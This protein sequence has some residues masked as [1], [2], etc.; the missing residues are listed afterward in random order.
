[1]ANTLFLA[2]QG[3]LQAWGERGRWA[4]RDSALLPTKSGIVGLLGCALGWAD[5][6]RLLALSQAIEIGV[7]ADGPGVLLTDYHTVVGGVLSAS[8]K[9]KR[10][11]TTKELE[12]VVS[13]RDYIA[14]AAFLAAI[15][16]PEEIISRCAAAVCRPVWPPYL[17]RKSCPPARPLYEGVGR[18]DSVEEALSQ[19]PRLAEAGPALE[20]GVTVEVPVEYGRGLRRSD[21]L[22]SR[23][24]RMYGVRSVQR[25]LVRPP[26]PPEEDP[27]T[28]PD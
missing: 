16:G 11:A 12:T 18:Y 13:W 17:G 5:D 8:G 2:L 22:L 9:V 27:C 28:S 23:A 15:R 4:V 25:L 21:E 24:R 10:N 3:P 6:A 20:G 26:E 19:W 14:D 1:M 7:R